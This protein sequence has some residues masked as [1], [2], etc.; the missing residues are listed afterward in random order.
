M[1]SEADG[2]LAQLR[3]LREEVRELRARVEDGGRC[4]H[5][6]EEGWITVKRKRRDEEDD[7]EEGGSGG[8]RLRV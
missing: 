8:K 4:A 3:E 2:L 1:M 6:D 5:E 7:E